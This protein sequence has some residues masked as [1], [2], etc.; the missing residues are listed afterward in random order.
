MSKHKSEVVI[1]GSNIEGYLSDLSREFVGKLKDQKK[2]IKK[3][4][5][6]YTIDDAGNIDCFMD[7]FGDYVKYDTDC[8]CFLYW[9]GRM[10]REDHEKRIFKWVQ[11]AMRLRRDYTYKQ[12]KKSTVTKDYKKIIAHVEKC[13]NTRSINAIIEGLKS[14]TTFKNMM[15]DTKPH[16]V[17]VLNGT[18]DLRTGEIKKHDAKDYITKL[19]PIEYAPDSKSEKFS[20]FL[21]ETFMDKSLEK[22]I[23]TLFGYCLTGETKEQV[24]H[25]LVGNGANGKS[26]LLSIVRYILSGYAEVLPAKVLTGCERAG[27]ASP[28]LAQLKHKRLVCCSEL[29]CNDTV[30]EGKLKIMSS[31][32]TLSVRQLYS[33]PFTYNPEFKCLIDTNYLPQITGTD[34]GI[35]RRIRIIPFKHTV[36]KKNI[37]KDLLDELKHCS[38]AILAWMIKGA[39]M[40]YNQGLKT[41]EAIDK[42]TNKY[43]RSQD[44]IGT[45]IDAYIVEQEDG[46]VRA[47][48]LYKSY[49][50]FCEDNLL[51][52]M[53][54][55]KF[56][57]DFATRGY[58]RSKDKISRKYIGIT[59]LTFLSAND[60]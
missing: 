46:V 9:T 42:A 6:K 51:N 36:D 53:S 2:N 40:Y 29:N 48:E 10:W 4:V 20:T 23:Q 13:C 59:L 34:Y 39:E 47:R 21:H 12:I 17:N 19:I 33:T 58:K 50:K 56:G 16:L 32:E 31:G 52:P 44:T 5:L 41:C 7:V 30:N 49:C 8:E 24:V 3:N 55:T 11:E 14:I 18:V 35:W 60:R 37:N 22:Y 26:T 45:F 25:F 54:E 28:E 38:K 43:R 27:A 15:W 57:M 1:H